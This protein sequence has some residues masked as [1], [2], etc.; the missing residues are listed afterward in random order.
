MKITNFV[1]EACAWRY[2]RATYTRKLHF[3]SAAEKRCAFR[4]GLGAW[5]SEDG[6][7]LAR[8]EA[9]ALDVQWAAL[10]KTTAE[11]DRAADFAKWLAVAEAERDK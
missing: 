10:Q 5:Y 2:R 3:W 4:D 6:V 1:A 11:A 8:E 9:E 7:R